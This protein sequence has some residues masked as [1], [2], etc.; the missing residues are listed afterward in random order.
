MERAFRS[1][2]GSQWARGPRLKIISALLG[3]LRSRWA[4]L[5]I[6]LDAS[7]NACYQVKRAQR[8]LKQTKFAE[9]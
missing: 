8:C 7:F 3:D 9:D 5:W 4:S 2:C 6:R 1:L